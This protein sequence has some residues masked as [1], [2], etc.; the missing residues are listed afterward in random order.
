MNRKMIDPLLLTCALVPAVAMAFGNQTSWT[1][2]WAQGVSEFVIK[3]K[4]DLF[5]RSVR[6]N[7]IVIPFIFAAIKSQRDA[8]GCQSSIKN[9]ADTLSG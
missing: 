8:Y 2:G 6:S 5:C 9:H 7:F 4:G 1:R 3:G